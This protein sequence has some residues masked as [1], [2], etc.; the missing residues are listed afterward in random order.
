[1]AIKI[2]LLTEFD[3]KGLKQA[4]A[5]FGKLSADVSSLGRNF[6]VLGAGIVA[7]TALLGKAVMSA[8]NF[9]AE[10]EGVNQV[11]KEAAASVQA[12]AEQASKSAGLSATEALR[13]SKTFGLF[14]TGA[15][16]GVEAAAGFSTTMVQLAG[17]LGSFNDVPTA[18]ALAAI[19]SGLMGQA[20]PLRNFGVF[21]DE[22]RLKQA[23]F[24]ATGVEVTGTL[25]SQQK[26]MAAYYA[27]LEQ[28]TVQQGDYV[29]YQDTLG[30]SLKTLSTDFENL[31][32]DIGL[33]LIPALTAAMPEI[34][35]MATSIGDQLKTAIESIDWISLIN[36]LVGVAGF[37]I[38]NAEAIAI[39]IGALFALNTMYKT[40]VIT[41]GIVNTAMALNTWFIAQFT[42][43]VGLGTIALKLFRTALI[44]TG[45]GAVLVGLGFLA[46]W[47][48]NASTATDKAADSTKN[49]NNQ[50]GMTADNAERLARAANQPFVMPAFNFSSGNAA[51][52]A[53][54]ASASSQPTVATAPSGL[55]AWLDNAAND[56]KKV[57]KRLAL[58]G[59]GLSE[60]VADSILSSS[61]PIN[62]AN[63][64]L[65]LI[66]S[67]GASAISTINKAFRRSEAGQ[68]LAA[69]KAEERARKEAERLAKQKA[70]LESFTNSVQQLYGQIKDS[71]MSA[72]N[73]PNLGNSVDSI[74]KNLKELLARTRSFAKNIASLGQ[75][76]LNST[77]L[78]QVISAGPQ[79]GS[80]LASAIVSGGTSFIDQL[81]A[82]YSEMG[83][84]AGEIAG[85]GTT[86]AFNNAQTVNNYS[87]AVTGGLATGPEVGAAVVNAIRNYERQSGSA[88][89]A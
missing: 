79:A 9:E 64:A 82:A 6:A 35:A 36:S 41:T 3:P 67:G 47:M 12:F 84:L 53:P 7:G 5:A 88:W 15:G 16:L 1:M 69:Q 74:T 32:R 86:S 8:S 57:K 26:M 61:D 4:N 43:G 18:D 51:G 60:A 33:M 11:F 78:Q 80:E 75:L 63:E 17:D 42:A 45:I 58:I 34:Q 77:L 76:G 20:E 48:I 62:A 22:A 27:I 89:R 37:F 54:A 25:D 71:I 81:N 44:T 68:A 19:Q 87:I 29:K 56:A 46:E 65:A 52:A 21:L 28:T 31:T 73:L 39:G 72:F 55:Q 85:V 24:N 23:L 70:A 59:A 66:A 10:F 14:A 30:N 40:V 13:A 49:Y 38:K 2:P 83:S 50:L